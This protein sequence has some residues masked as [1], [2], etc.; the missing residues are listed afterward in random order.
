MPLLEFFTNVAVA[1]KKGFLEAA[2]KAC[3]ET[4]GKPE[5]F[6]MVLVQ[7]NQALSF[8]GDTSAPAYLCTIS[9]IGRLGIEENQKHSKVIQEFVEAKL[10]I[11]TSQG[12]VIFR[13]V[14]PSEW[15]LGGQTFHGLI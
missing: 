13:D 7:D 6:M 3:A 14:V 9:S 15:A 11:P 5:K 1:D 4:L 10:N 12:Y 8:A 2:T